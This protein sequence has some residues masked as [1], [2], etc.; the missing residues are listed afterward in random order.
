MAD[1]PYRSPALDVANVAAHLPRMA[2]DRPEARAIVA[3]RGGLANVVRGAAELEYDALSYAQLDARA[4]AYASGLGEVGLARGDRVVLMVPPSLPFFALVF[5]MFEA[6]VVPVVL[7]PGMGIERLSRC[8]ERAEPAGF[9]GVPRAHAARRALGWGA[10]SIRT[11]IVVGGVLSG[12]LGGGRGARALSLSHLRALGERRGRQPLAA[13]S[14][15]DVAAILFTSG[16]TG[17]PKGAVYTHRNFLAQVEAIRAMYGIAPGEIDLPTFPLFALFDPAL[18]MTT[19]IPKMDFTRPGAVVGAQIVEPIRRFGVT[20]MF[21][22]PALLDRVAEQEGRRVVAGGPPLLPTLRRVITAGAPVSPRILESFQRF[23]APEARIHTP[24][25]ATESLP[26]ATIDHRTIL[27]ETRARTEAGEGI[28]VGRPVESATVVVLRITDAPRERFAE[29]DLCAEGEIGEICVAG[30]QVTS[31]YFRDDENTALH[32]MRDAEGRLF[33]RVGDVGWLDGDG[34]LWFCGRKSQRVV[35]GERTYFTERI[36][37]PFN[38][39]PTVKRAAFVGPTWN[40][41][42]VPSLCIEP[43]AFKL[44]PTAAAHVPAS[45]R[46]GDAAVIERFFVVERFPVDP[47]HNAKIHREELRAWCE[48]ALARGEGMTWE[49]IAAVRAR[50][51]R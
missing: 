26:V 33:H 16:S 28:C 3:P 12:L 15:D 47:R 37:G 30:P 24:Y 32:K 38:A 49:Q 17:V 29:S 35:V 5:G 40:G 7:D 44:P 34:R 2:R 20:N 8:I 18:G 42:V 39:L 50:G 6:G 10:S 9:I 21:G 14:E 51:N 4:A 27:D 1:A 45:M 31:S 43:M 13:V 23:L 48:A 19:V 36:E 46:T 41:R 25:G 22:S 11:N